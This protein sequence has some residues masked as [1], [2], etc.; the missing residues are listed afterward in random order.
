MKIVFVSSEAA[1]YAKTGGLADVAS[2]LPKALA[3]AGHEVKVFLPLYRT[4][5]ERFPHLA[6]RVAGRPEA[7]SV[8]EDREAS[9]PVYFI[10]HD[11]FFNRGHLY[12]TAAG[13]DPENGDRFAFFSRS[14]LE[15]L[16]A[17]DFSPEIIHT[18]DW[19]TAALFG[20][21]KFVMGDDPFFR[22]TKS[23]FTIHN[24]AYQGLFDPGVL[25]R[26]GLPKRLFRAEDL[27][28]FGRVN[29]LKAG[30]LYAD[31]V[32]T[33]SPRYAREI[34]TPEFGCGLDGLLRARRASI[35]GI[36]NGVDDSMWNPADDAMIAAPFGPDDLAGKKKC[37]KALLEA[38]G[39][40]PSVPELP[41]IGMVSRLVEQKGL[42]V[43]VDALDALSLLGIRIIIVG[44]GDPSI[45][46]QLIMA[47]NRFPQN[48]GLRITYDDALARKV[49]AGS[50]FFLIPSRY[51]PC[52]LTQMYSQKY[53]A[54]PIVRAVGGLDDTVEEFRPE[55]GEGTGFKFQDSDSGALVEAV[56]R[57]LGAWKNP[58]WM[59][60][61][62]RNGMRRDF[63]WKRSAG[64]YLGL[65][66][67][68]LG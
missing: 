59:S 15:A 61:L 4:I 13:D 41:V 23:V 67:E 47:L 51:E 19:Q 44:R 14:V 35:R 8:W 28:F 6:L 45:E 32:T 53:G 38:F 52:G 30:I 20:Y 22:G 54:V 64:A 29:F 66:R 12:C 57:A 33:V 31:A 11:Y 62:R 7:F 5:K 10:E 40:A 58:K 56:R 2:A 21:K 49:F 65:Y 36:L 48:L 46:R 27:E 26:I 16:R 39:F 9:V 34:Q 25:G 43:L 42:D 18:H 68:L 55:T 60:M 50:D 37:K 3:E 24:L 17:I 63:S 1:P